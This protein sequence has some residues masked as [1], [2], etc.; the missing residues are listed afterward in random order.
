MTYPD[1]LSEKSYVLTDGTE[2]IL[3]ANGK[4][5]LRAYNNNIDVLFKEANDTTFATIANVL[6]NT[7]K[8]IDVVFPT[9]NSKIKVVGGDA[10]IKVFKD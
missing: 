1:L 4:M 3:P 2:Q 10:Y 6:A 9:K 7:G 5:Y 8:M